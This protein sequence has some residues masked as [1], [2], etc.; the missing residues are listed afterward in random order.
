MDY[1]ELL[2]EA[3]GNHLITKEK[4]LKSCAGRIKGNRIAIKST[5]TT[6]EKK[7]VLAE[8][9]GH[10]YTTVGSILNQ[11]SAQNRR[12]EQQARLWSYN[13]RYYKFLPAWMPESG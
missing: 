2:M 7:C 3:D 12:Q 13:K 9:L 11:D 10:Y 5:L 6:T 1:T 8:E 4:P